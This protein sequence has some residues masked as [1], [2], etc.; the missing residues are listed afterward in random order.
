M[1]GVAVQELLPAEILKPTAT[2]HIANHFSFVERKMINAIM[3][4]FQMHSLRLGEYELPLTQLCYDINYTSRNREPL[5]EALE[6]LVTTAVKWNVFERD[7]VVEWGVCTFLSSAK[8]VRGGTVKYRVN[9]QISTWIANPTL[10]AKFYL[11]IQTRFSK[12]H[13]LIMYELFSDEL[14]RRRAMEVVMEPLK[15][16]DLKRLLGV[17]KGQYDEFKIFNRAVLKPSIEEINNSTDIGVHFELRRRARKV[18]EIEFSVRRKTS[19]QLPLPLDV[20][21]SDAI[22]P[23]AKLRKMIGNRALSDE[24][25][26]V[27]DRLIGQGVLEKRAT[28][29]IESYELSYISNKID[30]VEK[31][32]AVGKKLRNRGGYLADAIAEDYQESIMTVKTKSVHVPQPQYVCDADDKLTKKLEKI[33]PEWEKFRA[34]RARNIFNALSVEEQDEHREKYLKVGGI[35]GAK[36]TIFSQGGGWN[37][38]IILHEFTEKYLVKKLLT[39]P[40]ETSIENY[41]RW[42]NG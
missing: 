14:S 27:F 6:T 5:K 26:A 35:S 25:Q 23:V 36:Q 19:Y 24:Q 30:L 22:K 40:E 18:T 4:D 29:I 38:P 41:L 1:N 28:A 34:K 20:P 39:Q 12:K 42:K 32:I 15:I 9:E 16:N 10:F 11:L 21:E 37:N 7:K 2:I 8:I 13:S 17:A 3:A 31:A 33:R